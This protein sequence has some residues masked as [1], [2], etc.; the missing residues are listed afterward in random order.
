LIIL[1]LLVAVELAID[2]ILAAAVLVGLD[3][4]LLFL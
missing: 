4:A 3:L 1:L 2:I